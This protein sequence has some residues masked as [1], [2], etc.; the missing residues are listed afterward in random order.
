MGFCRWPP[1]RSHAVLKCL[2]S[3]TFALSVW[4]GVSSLLSAGGGFRVNLP[5]TP[6]KPANFLSATIDTRW[7]EGNGYCPIHVQ[8]NSLRGAVTQDRRI[9]VQMS[10]QGQA[11]SGLQPLVTKTLV[12][13]EGSGS[14]TG[15]MLFPQ[16]DD[17][18]IVKIQFFEGGAELRDMRFQQWVNPV[19]NYAWSEAA[20]TVLIIDSQAPPRQYRPATQSFV[21]AG[22]VA[23]RARE[24][25]AYE[26]PDVRPLSRVIGVSNQTLT[27]ADPTKLELLNH[28]NTL[29]RLELVSPQEAHDTWLAYSSCDYVIISLDDL[30]A[31][32][33]THP[34]KV[35]ALREWAAAGNV[36]CVY[37]VEQ[38]FERLGE[39][40]DALQI[41]GEGQQWKDPAASDFRAFF[42]YELGNADGSYVTVN[43]TQQWFTGADLVKQR[44]LEAA[45]DNKE[46]PATTAKKRRAAQF[47][48]DEFG[49][50]YVIA[51]SAN[52]P[53]PGTE[54]QWGWIFRTIQRTKFKWYQRFGMSLHRENP[55]FWNWL[56]P[57]VGLP[58]VFSFLVLIT[59]FA[60][61]IGPVN[62][63]FLYRLRRLYLL[64]V[65]VPAGALVV[66]VSLLLYALIMDGFSTKSRIRSVTHIDQPGNLAV[67]WSRQT[68][69]ASL[70]PSGGLVYPRFAAVYPLLAMPSESRNLG[71]T[72]RL[73]WNENQV[74]RRGYMRSRTPA[75]FMVVGAR[76][77][78]SELLVTEGSPLQVENRLETNLDLLVVRDSQGKFFVGRQLDNGERAELQP[79]SAGNLAALNLE[80]AKAFS[81]SKP[82]LP[83]GF[84]RDQYNSS[85][86]YRMRRSYSYV[87]SQESSV[88]YSTS[89][90]EKQLQVAN[91]RLR[92]MP[93]GSYLALV[94]VSPEVPLGVKRTQETSS[95][96]L[97]VG[98]W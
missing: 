14:V 40:E 67:S 39:C 55:D 25:E 7:V 83:K 36:L 95:F 21:G 78:L 62:Y 13:P 53:F 8:L 32:K 93:V 46:P 59:V 41:R 19:S 16:C 47:V 94:E 37:G 1:L 91:G 96:H 24:L 82:G 64:L 87:D 73:D 80:C 69:Y 72:R 98:K 43:G 85:Y 26:V 11:N 97:I 75:Q 9:R 57:G 89:I 23:R 34:D 27:R 3:A 28:I 58:P 4:L 18:G 20:P 76:S 30:L 79:V 48:Y 5:R 56:I 45:R 35:Q 65:T 77:S 71:T 31:M 51:L 17:G 63:F 70:A 92:N 81:E 49:L 90:L 66:T 12:I 74:L 84:R 6:T 22:G 52:E 10:F 42:E 54:R 88:R 86:T 38:E 2:V 15:Q 50:G 60:F 29:A 68:Y 61:V 44:E 33:Q